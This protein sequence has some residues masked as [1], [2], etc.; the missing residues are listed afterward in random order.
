[1]FPIEII[2]EIYKYAIVGLSLIPQSIANRLE[3]KP[4]YWNT[5]K[6]RWK[7][8]AV[9]YLYCSEKFSLDFILQN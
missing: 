4:S 6:S 2:I 1:M 8:T 9:F 7:L 5:V 3:H